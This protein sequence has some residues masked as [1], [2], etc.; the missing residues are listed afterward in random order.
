[1][2]A[3]APSRQTVITT[4]PLGMPA[5]PTSTPTTTRETKNGSLLG[6]LESV[7]GF[8]VQLLTEPVEHGKVIKDE[9]G[10]NPLDFL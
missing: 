10:G 8:Q 4:P 2:A 7:E 6:Q 5:P 3:P 9:T 1:M